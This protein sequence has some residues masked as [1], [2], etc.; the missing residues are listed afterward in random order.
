MT[1]LSQIKNHGSCCQLESPENILRGEKNRLWI[2]TLLTSPIFF[3]GMIAPMIPLEIP[4]SPWI[5]FVLTTVLISYC[6][7]HFF[8]SAWAALKI[9]KTN[10]DTL[11]TLG[12]SASFLY[13]LASLLFNRKDFYFD[14]AAM[15][16]TLILIGNF[17]ES[18][19]K[20]KASSAIQKL[21]ELKP[22]TAHV[23][24]NGTEYDLAAQNLQKG[25]ICV[26]LAGEKI[27][28]DGKIMEGKSLVDESMITGE[29]I[30]R[31][32]KP[33]DYVIGATING[34]GVIRILIEKSGEDT[35]FSGILKTVE[36]IKNSKMPIQ[37][38]A[39]HIAGYFVPV[40]VVISLLTLSLWWVAGDPLKGF[41]SAISVLIIACPC[42][43]GLATPIALR[44]SSQM[45]ARSGILFKEAAAL[46]TI[47]KVKQVV[48]D[49]TGTLTEGKLSVTRFTNVS[50]IPDPILLGK[51]ASLQ[52]KSTHPIAKALFEFAK[53][54][55]LL[56]EEPKD[57]KTYP[58]L[59]ICG[60]LDE[61]KILIGN[62]E[63]LK[64]N[65][66]SIDTPIGRW[67]TS[68]TTVYVSYDEKLAAHFQ[69]SDTLKEKSKSAISFLKSQGI[70]PILLTGDTS[71]P[72]KKI[73][74]DL[75]IKDVFWSQT[76]QDKTQ[77]IKEFKNKFPQQPI[78]MVGDGINDAPAL[79]ASDIGIAMGGGTDIAIESAKVVL[80]HG[81]ILKVTH[82]IYLGKKTLKIIKENFF[83]AFIYNSLAI[84]L[85][86]MGILNPMIGAACMSLSSLS[87][88]TNS[89]RLRNMKFNI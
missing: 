56:I 57:I 45:A 85:A 67:V 65:R 35:L 33:G 6:G 84:P 54:K 49:K 60:V 58:G 43:L 22:I 78:A 47:G 68:E 7:Q 51:I 86:A 40:V 41:L 34:E 75:D 77:K 28:A 23:I 79:M 15:I 82:A 62:G 42:A 46:E 16:I 25:D 39:D 71:L 21:L 38:V 89:L 24:R 83:L 66:I 13:S 61:K 59:G 2:A 64:E 72:S 55:P 87:V 12:V 53:K 9:K 70:K 18:L 14:S 19:S 11:I 27:P 50:S 76:P 81:D 73:A 4:F 10:M 26:V 69:L 48:F 30:P 52:K 88:I 74:E 37:R 3:L 36:I 29:S 31:V 1:E 17:L 20:R 5:Q 44:V 80:I 32:I 8:I 63:F